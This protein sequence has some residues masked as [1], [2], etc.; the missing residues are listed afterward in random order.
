MSPSLKWI[1][2]CSYFFLA[3]AE[4]G[5]RPTGVSAKISSRGCAG[6]A[7]LGACCGWLALQPARSPLLPGMLRRLRR[8][9]AQFERLP[10]GLVLR[11]RA[12]CRSGNLS[13]FH[14]PLAVADLQVAVAALRDDHLAACRGVAALP[15]D[16]QQ[17]PLVLHHPIV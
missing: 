9:L 3:L 7:H 13:P 4:G 6:H 14:E 17:A 15:L 5:R 2:S 10:V 11:F 16:L 12:R 1:R 8:R